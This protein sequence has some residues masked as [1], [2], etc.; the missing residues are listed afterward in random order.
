MVTSWFDAT[1]VNVAE[2]SSLVK[3]QLLEIKTASLD[4]GPL[5]HS[6]I[7]S[8]F[9]DE[10]FILLNPSLFS[11]PDQVLGLVSGG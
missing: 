2:S 3:L 4:S 1:Q 11:S 6:W 7:S 8:L 10:L 9:T 5:P